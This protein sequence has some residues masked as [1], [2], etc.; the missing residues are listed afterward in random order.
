M[1]GWIPPLPLV[2]GACAFGASWPV[3]FHLAQTGALGPSF[4]AF[5]W[6]HLVALG[7]ITLVA[8]AV[9]LHVIPAF[10]DTEWPLQPLARGCT[11]AFAAGAA[12]LIAGFFFSSIVALQVGGTVL[13]VSLGVYGA[14]LAQP[15]RAA[16][17]AIARAFGITF[18]L[19][20]VVAA[21]GAAF[22]FA[23]GGALPATVLARGPAAH[24]VLGIGGWL[25]LLVVGVSA[26]TMR[27]ISGVR[28]RWQP[29]HIVSSSAL[30][31]GAI[32]TAAGFAWALNAVVAIGCLLLFTGAVAYAI[33][34]ADILRRATVPH[35]PPQAFM[36]AACT[37][38]LVAGA[39]LVAAAFGAHTGSAIAFVALMGWIG[40]AVLAHLHH[41]GIRVLLTTVRGEDDE[42]RPQAVLTAPLTW[43]TFGLFQSAVLLAAAGLVASNPGLV[44]MGSVAGC[45]AFIAMVTNIAR[46][47]GMA[48]VAADM[49]R[50]RQSAP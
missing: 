9:L 17:S 50:S 19:L 37:W 46:A 43:S 23:L 33:D 41:I 3:L 22:T 4:A 10:L 31:A 38:A 15:L 1:R 5:G 24:A 48:N 35:R 29:M 44:E 42:T 2:L 39:L 40:S 47:L 27:P 12:T 28:S 16:W 34:I 30:L 14:C 13:L 32:V 6:V 11:L 7:W 26:R 25:S 45:A 49:S 21:L 18:L 20:L 8:L 36:A